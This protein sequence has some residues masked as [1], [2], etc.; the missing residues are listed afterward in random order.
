[1]D[2]ILERFVQNTLSKMSFSRSRPLMA[3]LLGSFECAVS[4]HKLKHMVPL[5]AAF[6][7]EELL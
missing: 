4:F 1:M 7:K 5:D 2:N 6:L 3:E